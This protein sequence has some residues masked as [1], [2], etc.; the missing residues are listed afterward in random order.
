MKKYAIFLLLALVP[1][2]FSCKEKIQPSLA[3]LVEITRLENQPY[4]MA[5]G[6]YAQPK[7]EVETSQ[8][9]GCGFVLGNKSS[10]SD[11]DGRVIDGNFIYD[12]TFWANVPYEDLDDNYEDCWFVR[13]FIIRNGKKDYSNAKSFYLLKPVTSITLTQKNVTVKAGETLALSVS[14]EPSDVQ[15]PGIAWA[16]DDESIATVDEEGVVTGVSR[17]KTKIHATEIEYGVVSDD[18]EVIVLGDTPDGAVDMGFGP[19]WAKTNLG[20]DHPTDLGKYAAWGETELSDGN[21]PK[22]FY[23]SKYKF[24]KV[25]NDGGNCTKYNATDNLRT[26]L[27]ED[28][29]VKTLK[30]APWRMPTRKDFTDL[31]DNCTITR[32]SGGMLF[33]SRINGQSLFFPY[34]GYWRENAWTD[35]YSLLESGAEGHYWTSEVVFKS[36]VSFSGTGSAHTL[37]V[38]KDESKVPAISSRAREDGL[39]VRG[40][41]DVD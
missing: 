38:S 26:L 40:V 1:V 16:S 13:A 36:G 2:L 33:T 5:I 37:L 18:C 24:M 34:A 8:I 35:V 32:Q 6:F 41:Y 27:P 23:W 31:I 29:I 19:Y 14:Y 30:G 10:V 21:T 12:D 17:G 3:S 39:S 9:T 15:H 4:A 28:D 22:G 20:A 7:E 11:A 25:Q